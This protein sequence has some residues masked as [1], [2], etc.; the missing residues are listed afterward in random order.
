MIDKYLK[1]ADSMLATIPDFFPESSID[2]VALSSAR[3]IISLIRM[4][5]K[6]GESVE[7]VKNVLEKWNDEKASRF[8][9]DETLS[10]WIRSRK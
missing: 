6:N 10:D 4:L 5:I 9:I 8:N 1:A 3:A 2:E 7:D